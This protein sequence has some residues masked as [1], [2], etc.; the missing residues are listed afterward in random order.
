MDWKDIGLYVLIAQS[1]FF[2]GVLWNKTVRNERDVSKV[3]EKIDGIWEYV[4]NGS[5]P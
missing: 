2:V 1:F 5:K 3:F 4:R